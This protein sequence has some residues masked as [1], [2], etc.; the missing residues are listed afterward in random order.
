MQEIYFTAPQGGTPAA[1][2]SLDLSTAIV[3]SLAEFTPTL[4]VGVDTF[5][6]KFLYYAANPDAN[7]RG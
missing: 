6:R 3:R 5:R 2:F 1:L 4:T 7:G